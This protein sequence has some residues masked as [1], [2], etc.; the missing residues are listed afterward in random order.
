MKEV[1][2]EVLIM[3][4]VKEVKVGMVKGGEGDDVGVGSGDD[5]GVGGGELS[6]F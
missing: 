2:V 6:T 4:V 3:M 5:V 1:K